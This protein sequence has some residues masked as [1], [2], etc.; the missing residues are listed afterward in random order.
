[1][2]PGSCYADSHSRLVELAAKADDDLRIEATPDWPLIDLLRHLT[3]VAADVVTG[4]VSKYAQPGWTARQV[5]E[6]AHLDRHAVL[7]EWELAAAELSK[8]LDDPSLDAFF[9][10][11]PLVDLTL[12]RQDIAEAL[13]IDAALTDAE[14]EI[15]WPRRRELL[16]AQIEG[17]GLPH[18]RLRTLDG[19]TW[20]SGGAPTCEVVAGDHE[21]WRSLNGRRSLSA[22]ES[23]QWIGGTIAPYAEVWPGL[24][25]TWPAN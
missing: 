25:F 12:H 14:R 21:L 18:I 3:G 23:F 17:L 24:A 8:M 7:A 16:T 15:L 13:E 20:E 4:N 6:R 5:A 2:G 10:T 11:A 19:D 9:R 22:V 1:M